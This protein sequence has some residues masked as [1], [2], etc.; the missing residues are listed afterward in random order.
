MKNGFLVINQIWLDRTL[1]Q[2]DARG[3][4]QPV[5]DNLPTVAEFKLVLEKKASAGDPQSLYLVRV[6]SIFFENWPTT[7]NLKFNF[8]TPYCNGL[9]EYEHSPMVPFVVSEPPMKE[10]TGVIKPIPYDVKLVNMR[11]FMWV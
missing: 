10:I 8:Q 11:P 3:L 2:D 6:I 1:A 9:S 4:G 7:N 5:V